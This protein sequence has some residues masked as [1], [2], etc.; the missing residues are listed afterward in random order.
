VQTEAKKK[1]NSQDRKIHWKKKMLLYMAA[2]GKGKQRWMTMH[3]C[4]NPQDP[5]LCPTKKDPK[6]PIFRYATHTHHGILVGLVLPG[7]S[8]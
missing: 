1:K 8:Q 5:R 7:V 4:K 6:I 3:F 2:E